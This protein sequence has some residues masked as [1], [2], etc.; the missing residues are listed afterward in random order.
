MTR[1]DEVDSLQMEITLL[2]QCRSRQITRYHG[3]IL[4]QGT[5]KLWIIMEVR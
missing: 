3:S 2:A 4:V 5:S 1:E